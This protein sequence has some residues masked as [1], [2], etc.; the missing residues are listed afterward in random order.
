MPLTVRKR[1]LHPFGCK[2]KIKNEL[3][4]T[5]SNKVKARSGTKV[6]VISNRYAT[7]LRGARRA[8]ILIYTMKG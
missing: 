5:H 6:A 7:A 2:F 4:T 8:Q 1:T 3:E